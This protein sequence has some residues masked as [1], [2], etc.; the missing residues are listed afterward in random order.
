MG[1]ASSRIMMI[2]DVKMNTTVEPCPLEPT[3]LALAGL[4]LL[5]CEH[6]ARSLQVIE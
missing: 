3:S 2:G 4:A 5:G 1:K 6:A